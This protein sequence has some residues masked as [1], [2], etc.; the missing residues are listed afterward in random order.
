MAKQNL[1]YDH[2]RGDTWKGMQLVLEKLENDGI[3]VIGPVDLTGCSVEAHFKISA[4]GSVV[5]KFST[6]DNTIQI[7]E[8][9]NGKIKFM[10]RKMDVP[11]NNYLFDVQVTFVNEEVETILSDCW[12]IVNDYTK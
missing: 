1:I 6:S 10:P 4:N 3:T 7:T 11:A 5:F 12:N 9:I 2:K 8:A